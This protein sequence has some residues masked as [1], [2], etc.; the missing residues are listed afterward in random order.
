MS[1]IRFAKSQQ[2]LGELVR[3]KQQGVVKTDAVGWGHL[4][5]A[6]R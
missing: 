3:V 6:I 4:G 2:K 5:G 1:R